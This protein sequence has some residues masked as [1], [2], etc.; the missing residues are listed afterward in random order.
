[1][2][3]KFYKH[4][5]FSNLLFQVQLFFFHFY[6]ELNT[7]LFQQQYSTC[8]SQQS[9]N[10]VIQQYIQQFLFISW[11]QYSRDL[12]FSTYVYLEFSNF[13]VCKQAS[14]FLLLMLDEKELHTNSSGYGVILPHLTCGMYLV[15]PQYPR[16]SYS[17]LCT[18]FS[19]FSGFW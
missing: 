15:I 14:I 1:M 3:P 16:T 13:Q 2:S 9:S 7:I 19:N 11:I 18:I 5:Q 6:F 8:V 12:I 4:F 10:P 17:V